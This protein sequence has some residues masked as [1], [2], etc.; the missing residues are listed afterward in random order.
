MYYLMAKESSQRKPDKNLFKGFENKETA[1]QTVVP[2]KE[3]SE[4]KLVGVNFQMP[5]SFKKEIDVFIAENELSLK[6]FFSLA[7]RAYIDNHKR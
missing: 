1:I 5:K 6:D 4:E 2:V 3:S 7:A